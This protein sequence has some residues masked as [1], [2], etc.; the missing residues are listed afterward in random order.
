MD[1]EA[2]CSPGGETPSP[3][4]GGF[5]DGTCLTSPSR[6]TPADGPP[7]S[8]RIRFQGDDEEDVTPAAERSDDR[9]GSSK[10]GGVFNSMQLKMLQMSGQD[11][12]SFM[13]EVRVRGGR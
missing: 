10:T 2:L 4:E 7:R 9:A 12:D 1:S 11:I 5:D 13:K 8:R 6:S 3:R